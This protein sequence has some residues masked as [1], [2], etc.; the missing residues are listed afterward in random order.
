MNNKKKQ[1]KE[2]SAKLYSLPW[3]TVHK[4][5]IIGKNT[6]LLCG[7]IYTHVYNRPSWYRF[8]VSLK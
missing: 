3:Q 1:K 6:V 7:S 5:D 8:D 2:T 4:I